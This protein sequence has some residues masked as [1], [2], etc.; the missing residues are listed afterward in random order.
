MIVFSDPID[1]GINEFWFIN[2]SV[3]KCQF[4]TEVAP[5]ICII[6][7]PNTYWPISWSKWS[8]W[9]KCSIHDFN[10]NNLILFFVEIWISSP[11]RYHEFTMVIIYTNIFIFKLN[12]VSFFI[13]VYTRFFICFQN[14]HVKIITTT[15]LCEVLS[16]FVSSTI[17]VDKNYKF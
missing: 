15:S 14:F 2:C 16:I 17:A 1:P 12:C 13:L 5:Y 11:S 3:Y 9:N 6:F 7:V 4:W 8:W 10:V